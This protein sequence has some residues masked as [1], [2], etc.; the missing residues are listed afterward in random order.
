MQKKIKKTV[1]FLF[2]IVG[3]ILLPKQKTEHNTY[4]FRPHNQ[5]KYIEQE[6]NIFN[7][8]ALKNEFLGLFFEKID[9]Y[10]E[11]N[12]CIYKNEII[13]KNNRWI[14]FETDRFKKLMDYHCTQLN[15]NN[16]FVS[17]P[18]WKAYLYISPDKKQICKQKND[19]ATILED[20]DKRLV[21]GWDRYGL[22]VFN[23]TEK[24]KYVLSNE[25]YNLVK[26][27]PD[28]VNNDI[29]K[30]VNID[31]PAGG[32]GNQ[33]FSYWTG[34]VYALK[35][36][37][38]PLF[39]YEGVL[40]SFLNLPFSTKNKVT[41]ETKKMPYFLK[42]YMHS[43]GYGF[44]SSDHYLNSDLDLIHISG[45]LQDWKNFV[46]Y[47]DYIR[48]NT[49]FKNQMSEKSKEI[50]EKM[51]QED[52]VAVH[53]RRGDYLFYGYILLNE[54]YYT[55]ATNYMKKHL[56]NPHFYIFTNDK[57]WV[58]TQFKIDAPFTIVDW[59]EK[60]YE[61][62]QLMSLCKNFI[63]ANSTFSWWGSFLSKNKRKIIISPNKLAEWNLDWINQML[64]PE[65]VVYDVDTYYYNANLKEYILK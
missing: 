30:F 52:S 14:Y 32:I 46:G 29:T 47:E 40:E 36:N 1:F 2:L 58:Q 15:T 45:Y 53:I 8:N 5:N 61:D 13:N 34:V 43:L 35:H 54:K 18:K 64:S 51:Q 38:I 11:K 7:D 27:N 39:Y 65:F 28:L 24:Y 31:L 33:L 19:C 50:S 22:E 55:Q 25:T 4:A 49:I 16:R 26:T 56:K 59:T 10:K 9:G 41:Y 42:N 48:E 60:D 57:S 12:I 37:K 63:I 6:R 20:S 3:V 44:G 21:V 17:T 23:Q 62:L